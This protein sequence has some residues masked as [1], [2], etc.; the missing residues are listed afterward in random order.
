MT[1]NSDIEGLSF[2][3]CYGPNYPGQCVAHWHTE[4]LLFFFAVNPDL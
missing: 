4:V 2:G 1:P 3:T